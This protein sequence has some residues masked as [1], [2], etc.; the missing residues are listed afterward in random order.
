M[1]RIIAVVVLMAGVFSSALASEKNDEAAC[2][3]A[4]TRHLP[5]IDGIKLK[6]AVATKNTTNELAVFYDV[7]LVVDVLGTLST[8]IYMCTISSLL[9]AERNVKIIRGPIV[10]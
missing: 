8:T 2:I 3:L 6:S 7:R 5:T 9:S 10:P 1:L 4:A